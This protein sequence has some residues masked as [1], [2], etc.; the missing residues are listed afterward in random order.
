MKDN[1]INITQGLVIISFENK[2]IEFIKTYDPSIYFE[3]RFTITFNELEE[4]YK[5]YKEIKNDKES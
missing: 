5:K 1:E 4:L 3:E 2:E